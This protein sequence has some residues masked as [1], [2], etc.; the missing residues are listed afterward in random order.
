MKPRELDQ[1]RPTYLVVAGVQRMAS[2]VIRRVYKTISFDKPRDRLSII[3]YV[4][5]QG[6]IPR[7]AKWVEVYKLIS[8]DEEAS[9]SRPTLSSL[10]KTAVSS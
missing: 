8:L 10:F 7:S 4:E 2:S 1:E 3:Q 5:S 6:W 9:G